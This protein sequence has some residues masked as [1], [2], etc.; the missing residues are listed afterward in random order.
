MQK[1][2]FENYQSP[3][4][5]VM[6]SAAIRDLHRLHPGKFLTDV[7]TSCPALWKYNPNITPL[8]SSDPGVAI[9][10]C[11]YP[12]IKES[13]AVPYHFL[14]GFM[15]FIGERLGVNLSPTA[16]KG[17]IHLGDD[18]RDASS[19]PEAIVGVAVPFWIVSAG[20]KFD[21]T[22]KWWDIARYQAV[23]DHFEGKILFV[24]VGS[25]EHYHP[26]LKSV[27]D[28]RGRTALRD[29]IRLV[30]HAQGV[31]TPVSLLMHLAAA[32]ESKEGEPA[33]RPCVVVAGGR[34]PAHWE[35]YPQH[36]FIHNNG[37]L[38]CC[39]SGGCWRAR[40]VPLGDGDDNDQPDSLCLDVIMYRNGVRREIAGGFQDTIA[41]PVENVR[42][43]PR[44]MDMITKDEVVRRIETYFQGGAIEYLNLRQSQI[45][46]IT[47][48]G[49]YER[50]GDSV[51]KIAD[52]TEALNTGGAEGREGG[53]APTTAGKNE[54]ISSYQ[55]RF[56]QCASSEYAYP[57]DRFAGRGVVICGGGE[58]YLPSTWVAINILRHVGCELPIELW[59]LG[60]GEMTQRMREILL[61]LGVKCV[62]AEAMREQFPVRTLGGW[63]MKPYAI[64]H[65]G[66]EEVFY[67]DADNVPV[68]NPE[69][70]FE[71]PE[72][73]ETGAIFWPDI[74]RLAPHRIIWSICGIPY[75]NEREFES[76]QIMV[77][78]K[79]C[80][81]ALNVAM[82]LNEYSDFYYRHF[83]GDKETFHLA[84]MKLDQA[85]GMPSRDADLKHNTL[86]QYDFD[87][88]LLFQH[89]NGD[90]WRL[91]PRNEAIPNF[92]LE[93]E[94][95]RALEHLDV[96]L[97]EDSAR[98]RRWT[99]PSRLPVEIETAE[100]LQTRIF[101]YRRIGKDH[102][103]MTFARNGKIERGAARYEIYWDVNQ[104]DGRIELEISSREA[105]TV[106]LRADVDGVWRGRWLTPEAMEI[107]LVPQPVSLGVA[108]IEQRRHIMEK[109]RESN[110]N[111][112]ESASVGPLAR[113]ERMRLF[114]ETFPRLIHI[115]EPANG[116]SSGDLERTAQSWKRKHPAWEIRIWRTADA[117]STLIPNKAAFNT[118]TDPTARADLLRYEI[119]YLH[120]GISI[121]AG[122]KCLRNLDPLLS[123][124]DTDFFAGVGVG[125]SRYS[126]PVS[127]SVV[128]ALPKSRLLRRLLD[129]IASFP[130]GPPAPGLS[131]TANHAPAFIA[132]DLLTRL[133][134]SSSDITIFPR[135]IF[136]PAP[137]EIS[138]AFSAPFPKSGNSDAERV[139][140]IPR[141]AIGEA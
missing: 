121:F 35:Q 23:V 83:L 57:G 13:N 110:G 84:W 85:Y 117:E 96:L 24:Q 18:E 113:V 86:Y 104:T 50:I 88:E 62:D 3:G 37:A 77:N 134:D 138:L 81:K 68:R 20:G 136:H 59:H 26:P 82:H 124:V 27:I 49:Q 118:V 78:K 33:S 137:T 38:R 80:W 40:T 94:C 42:F 106:R 34:E 36:Q 25:K 87:G 28:L 91:S 120:G 17:D 1:V 112:P 31:L 10:A 114:R 53:R 97:D 29:L 4:D 70:L 93:D 6:L 55:K 115:I 39:E 102:R 107:E 48:R 130:G 135:H 45:A 125:S 43:L 90:K 52:G 126:K 21:Y 54:A 65:S 14:H 133:A 105:P 75:R 72:Y 30:H 131:T 41:S 7:R 71:T 2:I 66:F 141:Q 132:S 63:E 139:S 61:L 116:E 60:P 101:M 11:H 123:M 69:F 46:K 22:I 100:E 99:P 128:G 51:P 74:W 103:P 32:V 98:I 89:R 76:G 109:R 92:L 19:E 8:E 119:A 56:E 12:L 15:Q 79:R 58:K 140:A 127:D 67:L 47:V 44:C 95:L 122:T 73:M 9:I 5:L 111:A 129:E 16:F 64:M 108:P